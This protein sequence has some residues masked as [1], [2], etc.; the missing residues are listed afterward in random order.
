MGR[1]TALDPVGTLVLVGA[2]FDVSTFGPLC[3]LAP[4]LER[5]WTLSDQSDMPWPVAF[6]HIRDVDF[7]CAGW[8]WG[9][10]KEGCEGE[11]GAGGGV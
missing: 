1:G 9:G 11:D 3:L 8:L 10:G 5:A 2:S 4:V 6:S 7:H